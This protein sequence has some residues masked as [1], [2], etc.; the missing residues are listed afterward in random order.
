MKIISIVGA[1]PQFI[2]LAPLSKEIRKRH[3]EVLIDTGQHYDEELAS[4]FY[5]EFQ[6]PKPDYSLGIGS[7]THAEQT[8]KMLIELERVLSQE[9]PDLAIVFGDTNSTLAGALSASKL[10]IPIAH[11]EAGLRSFDRSMPEEI[12]RIVTDHL[13]SL[14]FCPNELARQN[15]AAEGV[16]EGV[17]VVGDIMLDAL[18]SSLEA[19]KKH[20]KIL[21]TLYLQK[22]EYQFMT[23]HR[24][25]NTDN[26]QNLRSIIS[27]IGESGEKTVFP[28]HPRTMKYLESYGMKDDLPKNLI[29]TKPLSHMDT[30]WLVANSKRVLTDSGGL[31]KEA[32]ILGVPCITL[33]ENTEWT[34]TLRVGWNILVGA[35]KEKILRAIREFVPPAEHP[36]IFGPPGADVRMVSEIDK[37]LRSA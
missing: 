37:F 33:R 6:I 5:S 4:N 8:G 26:E 23:C 24:A 36:Y 35:N 11:V 32:Y 12:N 27:A 2:K 14:L 22:K 21:D 3:Q 7:G 15:L 34:D 17:S 18:N 28:V 19:A 30:I 20:S 16:T 29:I 13:S 1:R 10:G 25:S 31:Q 9:K